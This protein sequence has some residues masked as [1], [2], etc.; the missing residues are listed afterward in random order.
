MYR[1]TTPKLN[2]KLTTAIQATDITQLY[3]TIKSSNSEV[4]YELPNLEI[5][6]GEG[7]ITVSVRMSQHDTLTFQPGTL[8]I[9]ARIL[10]S[11]GLAYASNTKA[12]KISGILKGGEIS[13]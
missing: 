1:G 4:T 12:F 13:E 11:D 3:L 9:Q 8:N 6:Q 5:E 7:F 2:I 10:T